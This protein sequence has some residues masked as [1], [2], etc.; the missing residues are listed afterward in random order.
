MLIYVRENLLEE[1]IELLEKKPISREERENRKIAA[2]ML[3][4]ML[5]K[6]EPNG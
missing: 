6:E 5:T 3:K 2:N 4:K 1:V